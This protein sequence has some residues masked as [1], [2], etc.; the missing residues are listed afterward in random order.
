[1]MD[2]KVKVNVILTLRNLAAE[3]REQAGRY[4]ADAFKQE[5]HNATA[6]RL[7][8]AAKMIEAEP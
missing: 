5:L 3:K 7:D 1:M 6:Q 8:L 4:P 2:P